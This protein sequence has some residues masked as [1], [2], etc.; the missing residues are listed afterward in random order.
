MGSGA[1]GV[2]RGGGRRQGAG[3]KEQEASRTCI[4]LA[5]FGLK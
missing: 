1:G 5:Q 4:K 2:G 3:A